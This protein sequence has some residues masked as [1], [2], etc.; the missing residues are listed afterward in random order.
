MTEKSTDNDD[1]G[2][3]DNYDGNFRN[4]DHNDDWITKKHNKYGEFW[5]ENYH[6]RDYYM[7]KKGQQIQAWVAPPLW[8]MPQSKRDF[9]EDGFPIT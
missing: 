2:W 9:P 1:D 4:V 7:V 5:V 8:A 3:N 6:F